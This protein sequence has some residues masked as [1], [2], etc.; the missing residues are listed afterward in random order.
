MLV[1]HPY[2][3]LVV[4][5]QERILLAVA[6][7]CIAAVLAYFLVKALLYSAEHEYGE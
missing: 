5:P 4:P 7:L 2:L 6:L 1:N 3:S